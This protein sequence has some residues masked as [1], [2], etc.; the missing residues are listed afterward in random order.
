MWE[1]VLHLNTALT[2]GSAF[3]GR[4]RGREIF[5]GEAGTKSEM[6]CQIPNICSQ[7]QSSLS[8]SM[9]CSNNLLLKYSLP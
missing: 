3:G 2:I 8:P 1:Y 6:K 7:L 9:A 4:G 5:M